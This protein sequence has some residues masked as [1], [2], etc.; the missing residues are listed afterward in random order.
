MGNSDHMV[1]W[2]PWWGSRDCFSKG[3]ERKKELVAP[4]CPTLCTRQA[5]WSVEFSR[6]EYWVGCLALLQRIFLTQ[7]WNL[8]LPHYRQTL[9]HWSTWEALKRRVAVKGV[10][11]L[12]R[13]PGVCMVSLLLG[14]A[15][16]SIWHCLQITSVPLNLLSHEPRWQAKAKFFIRIIPCRRILIREAF[17]WGELLTLWSQFNTM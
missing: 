13:N 9:C 11:G 7:G 14:L 12:F 6:Q 8:G 5:P 4:S 1:S 16:G 15:G 17:P 2:F 3:E 10:T